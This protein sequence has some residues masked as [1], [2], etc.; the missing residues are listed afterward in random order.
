M[1]IFFILGAASILGL[2][3]IIVG[4][5]GVLIEKINVKKDEKCPSCDYKTGGIRV[6][7]ISKVVANKIFPT[8]YGDTYSIKYYFKC[9]KCGYE[10][11]H[12]ASVTVKDYSDITSKISAIAHKELKISGIP[13]Y[14]IEINDNLS[15]VWGRN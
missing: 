5:V 3:F 14:K 12:S 13:R 15:S 2:I 1:E 7:N 10:Q 8:C 6:E 9:S 11:T 4:S